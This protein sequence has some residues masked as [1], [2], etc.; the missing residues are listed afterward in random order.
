MHKTYLMDNY[1]QLKE[2]LA[3]VRELREIYQ[4]KKMPLFYLFIEKFKNSNLKEI[5]RFAKGLEKDLSA[6]ENP[7]A[8]P[9]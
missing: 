5:A 4:R 3:C 7:V 8:S 1:S 2:M 9:L 6:V